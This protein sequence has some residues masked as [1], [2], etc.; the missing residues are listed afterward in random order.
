MKKKGQRPTALKE[1]LD[2]RGKINVEVDGGGRVVAVW[3]GCQALPYTQ[4]LVG[5][6]RAQ[7]MRNAYMG[8]DIN[9]PK[10]HRIISNAPGAKAMPLAACMRSGAR[11]LEEDNEG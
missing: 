8:S 3:F 1:P 2:L 5:E 11:L 9:L 6:G 7:E 10:I 4:H